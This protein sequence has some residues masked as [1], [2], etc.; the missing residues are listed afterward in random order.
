MKKSLFTACILIALLI[1]CKSKKDYENNVRADFEKMASSFISG[2]FNTYL[3]YIYPKVLIG[4]G[5]RD[6]A[7]E[8]FNDYAVQMQN[9]GKK[10]QKITLGAISKPVDA[11]NEIH[12]TVTQ[13]V[14]MK[15]EGGVQVSE[16]ILLAISE[17]L[18]KKWTFFDVTM[19]DKEKIKMLIPDFNDKLE[20]PKTKESE[21]IPD[22]GK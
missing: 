10:V 18:G 13:F 14:E 12:C 5:G 15:V 22:K 9:Q 4:Y 17:D 2:D 16:T 19:I 11:G 3:N 6:R 20:L 7:I 1:S 21:F 8:M